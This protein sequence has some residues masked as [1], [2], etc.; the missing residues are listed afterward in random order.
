MAAAVEYASGVNFVYKTMRY[1]IQA[2]ENLWPVI[3]VSNEATMQ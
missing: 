1:K 3:S 2:C